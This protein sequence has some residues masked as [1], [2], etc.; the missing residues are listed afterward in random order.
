M[1]AAV[2]MIPRAAVKKIAAAEAW[3]MSK[4][5]ATGMNGTRRYGQPRGVNRNAVRPSFDPEFAIAPG[6]L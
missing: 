1:R 6:S 5:I 3:A 4:P 2:G